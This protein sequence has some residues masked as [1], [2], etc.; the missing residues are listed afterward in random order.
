MMIPPS[1]NVLRTAVGVLRQRWRDVVFAFVSFR[2]HL[3]RAFWPRKSNRFEEIDRFDTLNISVINLARRADRREH[4][5][6]ELRKLGIERFG[7]VEAVDAQDQYRWLGSLAGKRGCGESHFLL[8]ANN[9]GSE[10]PL[11]ILEDD[12]T[13]S[14]THRELLRVVNAFLRDPSLDVLCLHYESDRKREVSDLL[15]VAYAI[16]STAGYIVKPRAIP[17]LMRDFRRSTR[18]LENRRNA[19]IDHAW[20]RSQG[21]RYLFS[22]PTKRIARQ[23]PGFSDITGGNVPGK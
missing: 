1:R 13:F 23:T 17:G 2:W 14:C 3:R 4:I 11:V 9:A 12:I 7:F 6:V 19:P 21:V 5:D 10:Q 15:S 22:A 8:L 16:V 20:W 18:T